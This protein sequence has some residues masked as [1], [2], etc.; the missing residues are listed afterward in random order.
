M[1]YDFHSDS[2]A[3][4]DLLI[5]NS[6]KSIVPFIEQHL[7]AGK[8][9][10]GLRILELGCGEGGNLK[11]F[12]ARGAICTG[13]DLNGEKIVKGRELMAQ[14][15]ADGTLELFHD[16]IFNEALSGR[17]KGKFDLIILK[18]VI[19]HI[20][21]KAQAMRN[22]SSFLKEDGLFFIGWPPWAMPFG[23]HQQI[24]HSGLLKKLPWFHLLPKGPYVALLKAFG[25]PEEVWRELAEVHDYKVPIGMMHRL[26]REAGLK[27]E[28]DLYYLINPIYEDKFGFKTRLQFGWIKAIPGFRDLI[29]TSVYYLLKKA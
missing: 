28:A 27:K 12:A 9:L 7:P 19:E 26:I 13:F 6:E 8:I 1:P 14:H 3:Y 24:C 4:L 18:D 16:N 21:D 22:M 25:E 17:F 10:K 11:P 15:I 29:T 20:P 2:K 5:R 23:G